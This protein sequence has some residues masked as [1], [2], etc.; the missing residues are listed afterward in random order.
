MDY[1]LAVRILTVPKVVEGMISCLRNKDSCS[2]FHFNRTIE[3]GAKVDSWCSG[4]LA[5][6]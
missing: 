1:L 4:A 3:A 2:I 5:L 6:D